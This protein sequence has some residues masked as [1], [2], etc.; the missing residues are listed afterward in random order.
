MSKQICIVGAGIGG[1]AAAIRLAAAGHAVTVLEQLDRP[2]GKM[3]EVVANTPL[4]RFRFDTGPSVITLRPVFEDLW[5]AAGARLE[6]DVTFAPIDPITR[7]FWPDGLT[8]DATADE[9]AM[10]E[11]IRA[12]APADVDGYRRFL[13][14]AARL[15]A[16]V[17]G[18]FLYR[19]QPRLRD[20]LRLPLTDVLRIDGLRSMSAAI[21]AHVR[22]P[23]LV[24]LLE[25]FATYN[26]SSPY[27]APATLN[28]IAHVEMSLG[29]WYP[30]GGVF[31]L[32][33]AFERLALRL[34]VD[35]RYRAQ[36]AEIETM[37]GRA[38]GVRLLDGTKLPAEAVICNADVTHARRTL[39]TTGR[40]APRLEPSCSGFALLLGAPQTTPALAHHNIFFSRDYP[41]EFDALFRRG[42]PPED[43]TLYLCITSKTDPE[44]A[45]AGAENWFSLV[46]APALSEA[47][48]WTREGDGY[49]SRVMAA[50]RARVPGAA[51]LV[52]AFES[53]LTPVSLDAMYGG[54]RGAIYGFSSNTRAAAFLR[55]GNRAPDIRGL[56]FA[57]GSAHPGGGVP[58]VTLSGVAAAACVLEDLAY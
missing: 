11:R 28:V 41:A 54:N 31:A 10:L 23:H 39:L 20:L 36:V 8:L 26:G 3:G 15:H 52:P 57:G 48:D 1:L 14:Y 19:A 32:A 18:P 30:R 53:R 37:A 42:V 55:P 21:R 24:Q 4:G 17:G 46:N 56:Y 35:I 12:F 50:L 44:H 47:F 33:R 40:G 34:G 38:T 16:V 43:P 29:A 51:K 49:A 9:P 27:Q 58:L 45:P 2:G 13:R 6:D 25:R 22:D 7:Y 5:R